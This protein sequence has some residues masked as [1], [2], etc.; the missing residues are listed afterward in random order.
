MDKFDYAAPAELF[1]A[2]S[3][4]GHR[5][6]GYRRFENAAEAIRYVMEEMPSEF[7]GGTILEIDEQRFEAPDI[8]RLYAS[9]RYPL[10]RKRT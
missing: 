10:A 9:E 5:P 4:V 8:Q 1:P 7:L 2:R 3:K 6:V